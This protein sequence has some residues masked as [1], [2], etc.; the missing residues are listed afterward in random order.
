MPP[1]FAF[2]MCVWFYMRHYLNLKIMYSMAFP[3]PLTSQFATIGSYELNWETQQYKCW[4]AQAITFALLAA[5]QAV[6]MFWGFLI[7]RIAYRIV[8]KNIQ[9]DERS[10]YES[11]EEEE[12]EKKALIEES[13]ADEKEQLMNGV[14][15]GLANGKVLGDADEKGRSRLDVPNGGTHRMLRRSQSPV[16]Q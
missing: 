5:L 16:K 8:F 1:Y 10:E 7:L 15:N 12:A 3:T 4:I 6:N 13:R 11:D 14:R 2:F 9:E